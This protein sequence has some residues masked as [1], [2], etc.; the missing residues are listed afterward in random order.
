M[1]RSASKNIKI[2]GWHW[3]NSNYHFKFK[4]TTLIRVTSSNTLNF[5]LYISCL[6]TF[7]SFITTYISFKS[8]SDFYGYTLSI[9]G[10]GERKKCKQTRSARDKSMQTEIFKVEELSIEKFSNTVK[11]FFQNFLRGTPYQEKV[12]WQNPFKKKKR[13]KR[14]KRKKK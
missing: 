6:F 1:C 3:I 11:N 7:F 9:L 12:L 5:F 4:F 2:I 14:K 8:A 13:K 10:R